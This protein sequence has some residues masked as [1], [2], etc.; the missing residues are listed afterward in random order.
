[1]L[2]VCGKERKYD[3]LVYF[4]LQKPLKAL[5]TEICL[6]LELKIS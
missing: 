3:A 1:M 5:A 6:A 2:S 4:V